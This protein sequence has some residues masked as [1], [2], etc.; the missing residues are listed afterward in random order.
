MHLII[1]LKDGTRIERVMSE[2]VKVGVDRGI[3]T[4]IGKDGSIVRYS[5]LDVAKMTIE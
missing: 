1:L 3:L 4:V 2:V 5:I